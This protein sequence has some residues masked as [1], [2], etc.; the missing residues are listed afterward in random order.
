MPKI[1][2]M[3]TATMRFG[4][5]AIISGSTGEGSGYSDYAL[6]ISGNVKIS[7][8]SDLIFQKGESET[9]FIQF[10]NANDGSSYNA[11]FAYQ[12]AEHIYI[13]PGRGT[14]FY[15]QQRTNVG[16]A[17]YTFPFRVFDD[18]RVKFEVG[19]SDGN[20]SATDLPD[21]VIFNV[22][23]STDN[24]KN[25][26]FGGNVIT[27]GTLT[28]EKNLIVNG[29]TVISGSGNHPSLDVYGS[30]SGEYVAVIDNDQNSS[31]HVLK[32]LTDGNGSGSRVLEMVDGDGDTIFRAR[33]DGRFG[34]GPDGVSSMGAGTFVVGIDNSSHTSDIAISKRLQHLG[35]SDT[36]IDFE[37]DT[38]TLAAG[39]RNF[40][41]IEEDT[42]D[43][44]SV[45]LD[46]SYGSDVFLSVSGSIGTGQ[47]MS[48]FGGAVLVSGS[49]QVEQTA[50]IQDFMM[51]TVSADNTDL[52]TGTGLVTLRAPFGMEL[53]QI[54]RASLS[55][56]GT[57][58]T[59]IDINVG[60]STIMNTNKLIIDA[61]EG[62]STSASTAAA[63]TT[64]TINDDD[65]ITIDVD[66]A[67][68]G[69]RGLK[70]T[71]YYRRSL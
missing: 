22:S 9:S 64:T 44:I 66:A 68:T 3:G 1:K 69:A 14:D 58:Q 38:I 40:I 21:D 59:T 52:Q 17:P 65:Q 24:N 61:N 30:L 35:D 57:S 55:T 28:T 39:G 4:E 51:I 60:G 67:G 11:Y 45:G 62:T 37:P 32:L 33:A 47:D 15:L 48:V 41:K 6:V 46:S 19:Q 50:S 36:Y 53:Y 7:E 29:G 25:A 5:G 56:N 20:A 26:V 42:Q 13:S 12:A 18:G 16:G 43:Q 31:G 63:L 49:L 34:F 23:G 27:S 54:P 70:V 71:L 2:N 8:G 10:K